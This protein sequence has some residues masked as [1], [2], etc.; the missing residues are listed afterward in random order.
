VRHGQRLVMVFHGARS[1]D[2]HRPAVP[3][4][5]SAHFY[6]AGLIL[7]VARVGLPAEQRRNPRQIIDGKLARNLHGDSY[8]AGG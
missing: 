2:H 3:K 4:T 6:N 8:G 7:A 5:H 1:A